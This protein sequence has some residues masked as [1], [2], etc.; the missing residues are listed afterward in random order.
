MIR[1]GR[2]SEES[3]IYC[4]WETQVGLTGLL[5]SEKFEKT[6]FSETEK[7]Q[8]NLGI[9]SKS[10]RIIFRLSWSVMKINRIYFDRKK[11]ILHLV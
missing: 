2:E 6:M 11:S 3:H 10:G 1:L 5:Q 9:V 8:G 7:S 4:W